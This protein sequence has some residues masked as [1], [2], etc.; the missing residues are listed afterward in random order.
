[1]AARAIAAA[2]AG[3]LLLTLPDCCAVW[4][5]PALFPAIVGALLWGM[6]VFRLTASFL[7]PPQALSRRP[8]SRVAAAALGVLVA[9]IG[10]EALW[11]IAAA[12]SEPVLGCA[13]EVLAMS[14]AACCMVLV[15]RRWR[16]LTASRRQA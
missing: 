16:Q 5:Y 3:R 11:R 6:V 10:A 13:L 12:L 4:S 15:L 7:T 8:T 2:A 14:W 1:M 9:T